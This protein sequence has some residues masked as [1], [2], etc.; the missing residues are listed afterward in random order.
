MNELLDRI[1]SA[2][3]PHA[4]PN[5][6]IR[7][8]HFTANNTTKYFKIGAQFTAR[9]ILEW[10][11]ESGIVIASREYEDHQNVRDHI[12]NATLLRNMLGKHNYGRMKKY[13]AR[14]KFYAM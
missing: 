12:D 10:T 2:K 1:P 7:P 8:E 11:R 9:S 6:A 13:L 5:R 4:I 3:Q 14:T